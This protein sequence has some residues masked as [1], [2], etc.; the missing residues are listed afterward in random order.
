M[1][2]PGPR[3]RGRAPGPAG[4]KIKAAPL[5]GTFSRCVYYKGHRAASAAVAAPATAVYMDMLLQWP[6]TSAAAGGPAAVYMEM[7][8]VGRTARAASAAAGG[9]AT[10]VYMKILLLEAPDLCQFSF[11]GPLVGSVRWRPLV[12][13]FVVPV[14]V[15]PIMG[16]WPWPW[17]IL[18]LSGATMPSTGRKNNFPTRPR[19]WEQY[20]ATCHIGGPTG[21]SRRTSVDGRMVACIVGR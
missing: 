10:A 1:P 11:R 20:L 3:A 2:A 17:Q 8:L 13:N 6:P 18:A 4:G 9:P 21:L 12:G 19:R 7:L 5:V 14:A 15:D 16:Q